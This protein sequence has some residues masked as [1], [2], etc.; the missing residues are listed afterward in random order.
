MG[1]L[2]MQVVVLVVMLVLVDMV[3]LL[4]MQMGLV[5]LMCVLLEMLVGVVVRMLV[6]VHVQHVLVSVVPPMAILQ[7]ENQD[8]IFPSQCKT[9]ICSNPSTSCCFSLKSS[10]VSSLSFCLFVRKALHVSKLLSF[11]ATS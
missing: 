1:K 3:M 8:G 6:V 5:V 9:C 7:N 10:Q 2:T 11:P 4:H